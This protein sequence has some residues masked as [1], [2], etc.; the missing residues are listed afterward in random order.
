MT[1]TS[2]PTSPQ[3]FAFYDPDGSC[4]R[5]SQGTFPWDSGT[6]SGTWPKRGS[7][8]SGACYEH[9][10]WEP[11]T[12]G[13][14]SSSLLPTPAAQE[15]GGTVERY[16]E[17][18]ASHDGREST[19][20]PLSMLVRDLMPTP[21]SR[22]HKGRNQRDD[23]T[24]LPGAVGNL[25]PTPTV[26]DSFGA[27]NRTSGRSNPDSKH[28]DGVTLTDWTWEITGRTGAAGNPRSDDGNASSDDQPQR[29]PMTGDD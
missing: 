24:C 3:P 23:E 16:R 20:T 29:L 18:L 6:F 5:T 10:T 14:A 9:P 15:P 19:F 22:D 1:D 8:R 11:P 7:M 17:R 2:G 4:W 12:S 13:P 28:H 25:L 27:R 26:G 21:T